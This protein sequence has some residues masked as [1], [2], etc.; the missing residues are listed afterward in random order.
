MGKA[1]K[2]ILGIALLLVVG[3]IIWVN[4]M[5]GLD[6]IESASEEG[7][8]AAEKYL[9]QTEDI[10]EKM[11]VNSDGRAI[12]QAIKMFQIDK[13]RIPQSLDELRQ[14]GTLGGISG[15]DPWGQPYR[16]QRAQNSL[17]IISSGRDRSIDTEDDIIAVEITF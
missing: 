1:I 13:G 9:T 17:K 5:K 6:K 14:A 4:T 3:R 11:T 15:N 7:S 16:F 8:I 12:Q 2:F 10:K